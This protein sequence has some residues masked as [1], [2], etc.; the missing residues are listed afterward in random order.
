MVVPD[1]FKVHY[2]IEYNGK[3]YGGWS[4]EEIWEEIAADLDN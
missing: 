1:E 2:I 3:M 4:R